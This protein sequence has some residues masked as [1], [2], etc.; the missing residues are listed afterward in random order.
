MAGQAGGRTRSDGWQ[1]WILQFSS[2]FKIRN[3][4]RG[5]CAGADSGT[6][7]GSG[8]KTN[9]DQQGR[10]HE[11][12]QWVVQQGIRCP[13]YTVWISWI[14]LGIW[15]WRVWRADYDALQTYGRGQ[16]IFYSASQCW[17][18]CDDRRDRWLEGFCTDNRSAG[19][20][21]CWF[22]IS[23]GLAWGAGWNLYVGVLDYGQRR[24]WVPKRE[25]KV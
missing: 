18:E 14:W 5:Y 4:D 8:F 17:K 24:K 13:I 16:C 12:H 25:T 6:A 11:A 22:W 23:R 9:E 3:Y 2:N 15:L 19:R 20:F 21:F 10:W 1:K 7:S